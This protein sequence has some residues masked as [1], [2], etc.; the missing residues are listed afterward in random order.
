MKVDLTAEYV[1]SLLHYDPDTGVLTWRERSDVHPNVNSRMSGKV[2]GYIDKSIGYRCIRID[3][4]RYFAHRL[5]WFYVHGTWPNDQIDHINGDR[6]DNRFSNLR[7]ATNSENQ[8]NRGV[9]S[10]NTSGCKGVNWAK[11]ANKWRA[12]IMHN[13]KPKHLGYFDA[14]KLDEAAAAYAKAAREHHGEFARAA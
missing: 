13:G 1:L 11:H 5:A 9:Q 7:E 4:R 14:D 10:N 3:G 2:A 8:Q 12:A 6:S